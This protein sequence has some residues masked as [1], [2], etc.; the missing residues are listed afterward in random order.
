MISVVVCVK[1]EE[2]NIRRC[3]QSVQSIADEIIILDSFSTDK[4][5]EICE[6]FSKVKFYQ[7]NWEGFSQTKNKANSFATQKYIF[8]L[9]ADEELSNELQQEILQLKTQL[10]GLYRINR[11]SNYCGQWIY[12]SGWF[13]DQHIR[14]FPKEGSHW[15]GIVHEKLESN[16]TSEVS[17]LKGL[18]HHYSVT[19]FRDHLNKINSYSTLGAKALSEEKNIVSLGFSMILNPPIRFLRH[20]FMKLGFLDGIA[21][22]K[23]SLLSAYSVYLKYLKAIQIKIS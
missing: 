10:K 19:S 18:V 6:V 2:K 17:D 16:N 1:N 3:L 7:T 5:K 23:I 21:G 4:T 14:L 13:P 9:D 12:H 8:S 22:F 15:T 20:Y 11:L